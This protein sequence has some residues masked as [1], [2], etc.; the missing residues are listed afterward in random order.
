MLSEQ[1][2]CPEEQTC[3]RDKKSA[4]SEKGK[5]REN[6]CN[7]SVNSLQ[8]VWQKCFWFFFFFFF[9]CGRRQGSSRSAQGGRT[10][11]MEVF[12]WWSSWQTGCFDV[13]WIAS[14]FS[15]LNNMTL[16]RAH[17]INN[18]KEKESTILSHV[19]R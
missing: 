7:K 1:C 17:G 8:V 14:G 16:C 18:E 3:W 12:R 19:L 5:T 6:L 11:N 15:E 10:V 13:N 4:G 2:F 9:S